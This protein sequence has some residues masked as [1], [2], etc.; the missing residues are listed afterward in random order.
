M[1][2]V[3]PAAVEEVASVDGVLSAGAEQ[4]VALIEA[5]ASAELLAALRSRPRV[6][7]V[8]DPAVRSAAEW[9]PGFRIA[10]GGGWPVVGSLLEMTPV[11]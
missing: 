8:C 2:G 9:L 6:W 3:R 1:R 5:P 10:S 4:A 11:N 7:L